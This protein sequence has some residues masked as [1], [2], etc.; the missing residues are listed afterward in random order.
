M[1]LFVIASQFSLIW[2]L[3]KHVWVVKNEVHHLGSGLNSTTYQL[4]DFGQIIR[5][6]WASFF[7]FVKPGSNNTCLDGHY[8][9]E[10]R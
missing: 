6:S 3:Q 4:V 1:L 7:S 8:E 5:F 9:H 2:S 10:M